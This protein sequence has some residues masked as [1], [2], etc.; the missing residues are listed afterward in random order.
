MPLRAWWDGDLK[1]WCEVWSP[2]FSKGI[3]RRLSHLCCDRFVVALWQSLCGSTPWVSDHHFFQICPVAMLGTLPKNTLR[4]RR[5]FVELQ[6]FLV[7]IWQ[8]WAIKRNI[9]Y[10]SITM[11]MHFL[12]ENTFCLSF[13]SRVSV[14]KIGSAYK[15]L[16]GEARPF[17][18]TVVGRNSGDS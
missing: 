7:E 6:I 17:V 13:Y 3:R 1:H 12:R 4:F 8:Y 16:H 18:E 9:V 5:N 14:Y 2:W 11:R 15:S 10:E